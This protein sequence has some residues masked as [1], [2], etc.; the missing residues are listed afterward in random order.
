LLP[1]KLAAARLKLVMSKDL[2][3]SYV[4][5]ALWHVIP[6]ESPG[7]GTLAV[8]KWWRLYYDPV[9]VEKWSVDQLAA[10]LYHEVWHLLRDHAAR[11]EAMEADVQIWN[12]AA[13]AE[14]NDNIDT[15]G[16][17]LPEGAIFPWTL[18]LPHDK[19]VEEYYQI[20]WAQQPASQRENRSGSQKDQSAEIR[21]SSSGQGGSQSDQDENA[22]QAGESP[23]G[24]DGKN[25]TGS[26]QPGQQGGAEDKGDALE[27]PAGDTGG[28]DQSV[29]SVSSGASSNTTVPSQS[30]EGRV[31]DNDRPGTASG[32]RGSDQ[33][34][35]AAQTPAPTAGRC[36]SCAHGHREPWELPPPDQ[37]GTPGV[38]KTEADLIRRQIAD[39]IR[40]AASKDL[41]SI[42][43]YWARWAE[44]ILAPPKVDWRR[45]LASALRQSL[46]T[47]GGAVDY[48][49]A[50]PSRRQAV[51]GEIIMPS[52]RQPVPQIAVVVDT[53]GSMGDSQIHTALCE[54]A[55]ILRTCEHR[56]PVT[57]VA[58]DA[59]VQ[60]VGKAFRP[61]QVRDLLIGGGGTDMGV[62]LSHV[63]RIKPRPK[64]TVVIT[65]GYTPWPDNP[66]SNMDTIVVLVGDGTSPSWAK[67]IRV[68]T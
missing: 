51:F 54:V 48:S 42:P 57:V 64:L 4:A 47:I 18:E 39:K 35:A 68:D 45:E 29:P 7:L 21:D 14:I 53:S 66:P 9:A 30:K 5:S 61:D 11:A 27:N 19:L 10:A 13:D 55:G 63:E 12:I 37:S 56:E 3:R 40:T 25:Q 26:H 62:A 1:E 49:Y 67:T 34:D 20:L 15:E 16:L 60:A 28:V 32:D 58:C 50:R 6:V 23:C 38:S 33:A 22:N 59:A 41:G 43:G 44:E 24:A 46:T 52:L 2:A 36:G 8:D 17:E 31:G 65:D